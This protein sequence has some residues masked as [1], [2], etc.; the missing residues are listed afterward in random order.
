MVWCSAA[1]AATAGPSAAVQVKL[2]RFLQVL[3]QLQQLQCLRLTLHCTQA[4]AE[5][6][7]QLQQLRVLRLSLDKTPGDSTPHPEHLFDAE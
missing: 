6:V 7:G 4:S 2:C 5:L 3:Q 1:A